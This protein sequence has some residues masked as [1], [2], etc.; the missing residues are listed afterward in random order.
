M[1]ELEYLATP[2]WHKMPHVRAARSIAADHILAELMKAR[3]AIFCPISQTYHLRHLLP[4][5]FETWAVEWDCQILAHCQ[6]LL[7]AVMPG[8]HLSKGMRREVLFAK[9]KGIDIAPVE[10]E[11]IL[12]RA[13]YDDGVNS[14]TLWNVCAGPPGAVTSVPSFSEY[15]STTIG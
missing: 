10:V 2:F 13:A 5:N 9:E 6:R 8:Y 7:V 1:V 11:T 15:M 14:G 4:A 12:K 3:R